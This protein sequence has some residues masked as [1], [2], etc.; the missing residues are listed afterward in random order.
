MN[1]KYLDYIEKEQ[2]E[3]ENAKAAVN[4][5]LNYKTINI[6]EFFLLQKKNFL[7]LFGLISISE[8]LGIKLLISC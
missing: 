8:K 1:K 7:K 6:F 2:I 3:L 5:I 4:M